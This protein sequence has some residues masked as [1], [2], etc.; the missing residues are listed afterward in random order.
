MRKINTVKAEGMMGGQKDSKAQPRQHHDFLKKD[1]TSI[2][3]DPIVGRS[4]DTETNPISE[5]ESIPETLDYRNLCKP[6]Q[7]LY[8]AE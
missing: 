8:G 7:G 4:D 5:T 6:V 2:S 3:I 1:S